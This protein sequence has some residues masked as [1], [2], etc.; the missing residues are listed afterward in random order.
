M[1]QNDGTSSPRQATLTVCLL[2]GNEPKSC[3]GQT[4]QNTETR[5]EHIATRITAP[6]RLF[7][8]F[9]RLIV[10]QQQTGGGA[11][12]GLDLGYSSDPWPTDERE[13][14]RLRCHPIGSMGAS[15]KSQA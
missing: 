3:A 10:R 7:M 11:K 12:R 6:L 9:P 2:S 13:G 4:P 15:I 1:P 8:E 5:I 14:L